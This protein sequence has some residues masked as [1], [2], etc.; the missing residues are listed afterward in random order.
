MYYFDVLGSMEKNKI[1]YLVVGG[2]AVNLY[3][4]QVKEMENKK[5]IDKGIGSSI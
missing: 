5:I 2:L 3:I 4:N 1:K